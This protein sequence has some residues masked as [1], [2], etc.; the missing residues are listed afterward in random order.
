ML[1]EFRN[2]RYGAGLVAGATR[3]A[4]RIAQGRT[5]TL[6]GVEM[7]RA[8]VRGR[9]GTPI[10]LPIVVF[11]V[12][13]LLRGTLGPPRGGMRRWGGGGWSGW[14]SGVGGFGGGFGGGGG[15][16]GGGGFG[17]GF[18]GFGGG[19]SGGGGGGGSW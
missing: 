9:S 8:R 4:A 6:T 10:W 5:V 17:G 16:F 3:L 19:R 13:L 11:I 2:G 18:G 15:G 12:I 7:P 14:S 1:P